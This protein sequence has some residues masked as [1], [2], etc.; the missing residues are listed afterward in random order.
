MLLRLGISM[1][2]LLNYVCAAQSAIRLP[3]T[4]QIVTVQ[5]AFRVLYEDLD[6]QVRDLTLPPGREEPAIARAWP[7]VLILKK[8][9]TLVVRGL[10][11]QVQNPAARNFV[12][13]IAASP[14]VTVVNTGETAT[15]VIRIALKHP[16]VGSN[17]VPLDQ[18][19]ASLYDPSDQKVICETPDVRVLE[20]TIM[21]F[22]AVGGFTRSWPSIAYTDSPALL[23]WRDPHTRAGEGHVF[24]EP[25][26]VSREPSEAYHTLENLG[27]TLYHQFR[28][29]LKH[30]QVSSPSR[31]Q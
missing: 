11:D 13:L 10:V 22:T 28:I 8:E 18:Q 7:S 6:V 19:D 27:S 24:L 5:P 31:L 3:E 30:S 21:P 26:G 25:I 16:G 17:A 12:A 2:V 15:N 9:K 1:S 20:I 29:E 14:E 4:R 23:E